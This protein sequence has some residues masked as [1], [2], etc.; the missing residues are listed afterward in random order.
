[1][2]YGEFLEITEERVR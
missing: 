2:T 1:V